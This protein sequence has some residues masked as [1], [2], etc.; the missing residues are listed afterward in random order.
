MV[1]Q[2]DSSPSYETLRP[3]R[4]LVAVV[5]ILHLWSDISVLGPHM[6]SKGAQRAQVGSA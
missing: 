2:V 5:V 1:R 6:R 3:A 4:G